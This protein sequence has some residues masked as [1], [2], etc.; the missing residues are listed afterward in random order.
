MTHGDSLTLT[1]QAT[2]RSLEE[3]LG[4]ALLPHRDPLRPR[5]HYA[6]TD[7]F[8]AATSRHLASVEAVL[9]DRVRHSVPDGH[10][11]GHE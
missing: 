2:Q 5:D 7:T 11:L 8:L 9:V 6:A 3:R 4:E 10:E 1:V